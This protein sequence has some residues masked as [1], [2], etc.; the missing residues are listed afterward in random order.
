[1][2]TL[3]PSR[4][5]LPDL[6]ART[7]EAAVDYALTLL[8]AD[9][10]EPGLRWAAAALEAHP[11]M[12]GALIVTAR[13]L[14][15]MGRA[16]AAADALRL[17]VR[18]A[19][20][21]GDL[22]LALAAVDDLRLL[23]L[24]AGEE[25]D[26]LAATFGRGSSRLREAPIPRLFAQSP[27]GEFL[28]PLSPYLS[29]PALASKAT[30]I[31]DAARRA[32]H[33]SGGDDGP[34]VA[35]APLFSSLSQESLRKLL[36][37][38]H[39]ITVPAGHRLI[40]EG[41]PGAAAYI[42]ARGE[43]EVSRHAAHGGDKLAL[44]LARLGS[45]A[46][47]GEMSLL[48]QLPSGTT[49]TATRP[50]IL[51]V[52]EREVLLTLAGRRPEVAIQLAAHCRQSTLA[53]LGSATPLV[54]TLPPQE[55]ATLVERLEMRVYEAGERL[56]RD[57][58]DAEGLHFVISGEVAVVAQQGGERVLLAS[59]GLGET[60]G[61][62]E[63]VLCQRR[64]ADAVAMR[65]TATLFL[66]RDEYRTLVQDH[67]GILHGL[68]AA[69]MRR[70]TETRL[71]LQ[72]G[73]GIAA[74]ALVADDE[75]PTVHRFSPV[76]SAPPLRV[77]PALPAAPLAHEPPRRSTPPAVPARAAQRAQTAQATQASQGGRPAPTSQGQPPQG[78]STIAP[79]SASVR[80]PPPATPM[81]SL[82]AWLTAAGAAIGAAAAT[83]VV[84][85]LVDGKPAAAPAAA[86]PSPNATAPV[87]AVT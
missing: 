84:V 43:V 47:F 30:Q 32:L 77:R 51:L 4:P 22:P 59:L 46:L 26:R 60:I 7:S 85:A 49:V 15:Q 23:G 6:G 75:E 5:S 86:A 58:A 40:Q 67:P 33:A 63:L 37:A 70:H 73:S 76:P 17:A 53:N 57:G 74:E 71:A 79:S 1:M 11:G 69:A 55:R 25:L 64:Y 8:V 38:F 52:A 18:R 16:R 78:P 56:A 68:Y 80:P 10:T 28:Q 20:D 9:E 31:V 87:A 44:A 34:P 54:A 35:P 39:V 27:S 66:S 41:Q 42:V 45:G 13:G 62:V 83:V 21:A 29:G 12:A 81:R 24:A 82:Q 61:E 50:S 72:A 2:S 19:T 14:D 48:S 65:P 36:G 3:Y